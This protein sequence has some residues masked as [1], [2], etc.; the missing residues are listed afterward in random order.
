LKSRIAQAL[1]KLEKAPPEG[2]IKKL[3]G[4]DGYRVRIGDYRILF[5]I[6]N[7][8]VSIYKIA[9]RGQAYKEN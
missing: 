7:D 8:T 3:E 5:D 2:D 9:P 1:R 4:R 6:E